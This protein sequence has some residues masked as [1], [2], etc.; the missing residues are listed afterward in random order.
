MSTVQPADQ[1]TTNSGPSNIPHWPYR[2]WFVSVNA[3]TW[4]W[5]VYEVIG[6]A[7]PDWLWPT[8]EIAETILALSIKLSWPSQSHSRN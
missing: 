7:R 5:Y 1:H 4:H 3:T 2:G 8:K 6:N